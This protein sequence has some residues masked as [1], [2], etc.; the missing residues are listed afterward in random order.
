MSSIIWLFFSLFLEL[1]VLRRTKK[2]VF[3]AIFLCNF[4]KTREKLTIVKVKL[5]K[6]AT[7]YMMEYIKMNR[8]IGDADKYQ[9]KKKMITIFPYIN[10]KLVCEILKKKKK[11]KTPTK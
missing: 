9:Y 8:K 11:K 10:K 5:D 1:C 4:L 3:Y 2:L 7:N 6:N